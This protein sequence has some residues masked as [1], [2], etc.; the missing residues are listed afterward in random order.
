MLVS[1]GCL[2]G[3][4]L[5]LEVGIRECGGDLTRDVRISGQSI[6]LTLEV[7][8]HKCGGDLTRDVLLHEGC[9][10]L[11]RDVRISGQSVDLTLEVGFL[12][13]GDLRLEARY[14]FIGGEGVELTLECLQSLTKLVDLAK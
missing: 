11:T 1:Q 14:I 6:D 10:D 9:G 2:K 12:E 3:S 13:G 5:T 7:F 8:G 4:D